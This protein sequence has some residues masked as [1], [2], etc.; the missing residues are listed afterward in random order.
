MAKNIYD[1]LVEFDPNNK[2]YFERN[3]SKFIEE[4]NHTDEQI[5]NLKKNAQT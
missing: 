4:I 2:A 5:K 1:T 3:Y